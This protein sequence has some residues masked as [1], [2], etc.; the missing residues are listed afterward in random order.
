M[1]NLANKIIDI[2][3]SL[4]KAQ[5][6]I[7]AFSIYRANNDVRDALPLF[8]ASLSLWERELF[9]LTSVENESVSELSKEQF[10]IDY[11]SSVNNI[12]SNI[13]GLIGN[14]K[15]EEKIKNLLNESKILLNEYFTNKLEIIN[16]IKSHKKLRLKLIIEGGLD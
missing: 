1:P 4:R 9:Q 8:S 7:E 16:E 5:G 13:S 2:I 10:Y 12:T 3:S 6:S 15:S 11:S 14:S